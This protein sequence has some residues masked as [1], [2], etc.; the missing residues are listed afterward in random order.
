M[1]ED[2]NALRIEKS[3]KAGFPD[4]RGGTRFWIVL[5]FGLAAALAI[6]S[7]L[8][9]RDRGGG[10]EPSTDPAGAA[11]APLAQE[12]KPSR[13]SRE[14]L[15]ASGYVVA[16]HKHELGS[17]VMGRVEWIGVEKGDLVRK[18]QLLVKLED[19]EYRA[20]LE[21]ARASL[22][23]AE[24]R[25]AE[26]EA[27]SRPEEIRR[28]E[29][30]LA[31]AE[32]DRLNARLELERVQQLLKSGVFSPQQV[33]NAK[34]RF[35]MAEATV[36]AAAHTLELLREG[37]RA[38]QIRQARAE[39]E[40]A[41]AAARYA[42]AL[43][44]A[45]EIRAPITGTVL[46]RI[47][48]VGEMITTSFA[49]ETGA[50]SAVVAL[51]DLNDLQVELDIAQTDFNRISPELECQMNPE[52]YPD[53]E[54]RCVIDEVSPEANRQ[55]ASIQ[56]KVKVLQPDDFLRPEMSARVTFSRKEGE[57]P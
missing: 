56:V 9:F 1:G 3:K 43:L 20:Q 19:R 4:R 54:Y 36:R 29:A 51:A 21:Q 34:A 22:K 33:D 24:E 17:K 25:L 12:S 31:R 46:R 28:A 23:L 8:A 38:E 5:S 42:E 55:R 2:L 44:D 27:G 18:G 37:P 48:E 32:A 30:E 47:A 7:Y 41:R 26:L 10:A 57:Q 6:T 14:V 45:T 52:A 39:V 53:R 50:K 11:V 15:V 13:P 49:G 40:R 16:H 35:A